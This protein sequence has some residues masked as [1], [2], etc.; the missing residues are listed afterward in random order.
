MSPSG[1]RLCAPPGLQSSV[2]EALLEHGVI[3]SPGAGPRAP[4]GRRCW[5]L[6]PPGGS[7][8]GGCRGGPEPTATVLVQGFG[9]PWAR[10]LCRAWCPPWP[11]VLSL[12]WALGPPGRGHCAGLGAPLGP[13]VSGFVPPGPAGVGLCAPLSG[14]PLEGAFSR[15]LHGRA[16]VLGFGPPS[17]PRRRAWRPPGSA[18]PQRDRRRPRAT[19]SQAWALGPPGPSGGRSAP[20]GLSRVWASC[21]LGPG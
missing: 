15:V 7:T 4:L 12:R 3:Y 19:R 10:P 6:V 8:P 11:P 20:D 9:P 17:A 18:A 13:P 16:V 1:E 14:T 21:P 2:N 5:D